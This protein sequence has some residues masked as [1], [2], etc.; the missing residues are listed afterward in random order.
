MYYDKINLY[1]I[2]SPLFANVPCNDHEPLGVMD[3]AE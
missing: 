1:D 3:L 2:K